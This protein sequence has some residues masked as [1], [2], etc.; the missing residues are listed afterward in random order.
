MAIHEEK[1]LPGGGGG[2]GKKP[3]AQKKGDIFLENFLPFL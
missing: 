2:G 3:T 1:T